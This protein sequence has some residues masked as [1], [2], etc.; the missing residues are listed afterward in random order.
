M[1]DFDWNTVVRRKDAFRDREAAR[2]YAEKLRVLDRLRERAVQ[3]RGTSTVP[4]VAPVANMSLGLGANSVDLSAVATNSLN[5]S[6]FGASPTLVS[7]ITS[8][9][10]GSS[11][12]I[13]RQD[14][15]T[16]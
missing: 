9:R 5:V 14:E 3:L 16:R 6:V 2:P 1:S 15:S 8:A 13:T 7:A 11:L 10:A 4:D 12:A